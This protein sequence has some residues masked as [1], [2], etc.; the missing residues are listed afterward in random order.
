MLASR[1]LVFVAGCSAAFSLQAQNADM[2]FK[3]GCSRQAP[4]VMRP[5]VVEKLGELEAALSRGDL[6]QAHSSI[7]EAEGATTDVAGW[8]GALAMKCLDDQQLYRRYFLDSQELWRL[9]ADANPQD[10]GTRIRAALWTASRDD[11]KGAKDVIASIPDGYR[12]YHQAWD[13]SMRTAD[14]VAYHRQTGAFILPEETAIERQAH[15]VIELIDTHSRQRSEDAL[16]REKESFYRDPTEFEKDGAQTLEDLSQFAGTMAGVEMNAAEQTEYQFARQRIRESRE[17][18]NEARGWEFSAY[19]VEE[20]S[21]AD[22]RAAERGDAVMSWAG[23]ENLSF[24]VRDDYYERAL[25][26]YNWCQCK[27]KAARAVTAKEAIQPQ[28]LAEQARRQAQADEAKK[29]L[30]GQAEEMQRAVDDM[31]KTDE[32]KKAFKDEAD[33]LEAELGF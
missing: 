14:G 27:E 13:Y 8:T 9:Q 1:T 5:I 25:G 32:E 3:D 29:R 16:V 18:L 33:D 21:P 6:E 17:Q 23:N 10:I 7:A 31:Q 24:T 20:E 28:L 30:Q 12:N 2:A 26:Y 15:Q 22:R 11:N 19:S 4:E